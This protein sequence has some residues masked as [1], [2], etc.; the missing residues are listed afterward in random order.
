MISKVTQIAYN[1][2][3]MDKY[4]HIFPTISHF[5]MVCRTE[6]R[7]HGQSDMQADVF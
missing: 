6:S 7:G 1:V 2:L 5:T 4:A 3:K